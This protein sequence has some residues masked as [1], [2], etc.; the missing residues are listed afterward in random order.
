M[1]H[2]AQ[3]DLVAVGI[4]GEAPEGGFDHAAVRA[5]DADFTLWLRGH[6]DFRRYA[7]TELLFPGFDVAAHF[8][9]DCFARFREWKNKLDPSGRLAPGLLDLPAQR[10]SA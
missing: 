9:A 3:Q 1:I 8:G 10:A 5:L 2:P 6:P 4:W 7:Q